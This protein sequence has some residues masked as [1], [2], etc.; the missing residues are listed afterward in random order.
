[1]DSFWWTVFVDSSEGYFRWPDFDDS[2]YTF[3]VDTGLHQ[4]LIFHVDRDF[5]LTG[6]VTEY[7]TIPDP[8]VL[9]RRGK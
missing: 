5:M 3:A 2:F 6:L 7:N 1:M 9:L 8:S 4:L